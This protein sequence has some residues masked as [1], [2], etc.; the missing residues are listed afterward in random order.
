MLNKR[1]TKHVGPFKQAT[2]VKVKTPIAVSSV[3]N[4]SFFFPGIKQQLASHQYYLLLSLIERTIDQSV[5]VG[6][7]ELTTNCTC[8]TVKKNHRNLHHQ[9]L[10]QC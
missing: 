6:N 5:K 1:D 7:K 2:M 3:S 10:H 9:A 8:I 4:F